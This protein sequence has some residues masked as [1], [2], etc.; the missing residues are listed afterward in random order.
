MTEARVW[1]EMPDGGSWDLVK[2]MSEN[3]DANTVSVELPNGKAADFPRDRTY[4]LDPSHL[5]D[6]DDLCHMNN[7]HEAPLLN[8]I[9]S[10]LSKEKIYTYTGDVLISLNPYK[11]IDGLYDNPSKYFDAP[12]KYDLD[13]DNEDSFRQ[14]SHSDTSLPP[15]VYAIA[16]YAFQAM[17]NKQ[18]VSIS[19]TGQNVCVNQSVIVSGESGAGK[20]EASKHVMNFLISTNQSILS[21]NSVMSSTVVPDVGDHIKGVLLE[22]SVV[23]EAFGNAKTVRN[24]NSSRF[25]KYIKLNYTA[26]NELVSA[27]TETFLLEKSRLVSVGQN[28]RNYHVFYQLVRGVAATNSSLMTELRLTSVDSF[29][30]LIGGKCTVVESEESDQRDFGMLCNALNVLGFSKEDVTGLWRL[31]ACILH[32]GNVTFAVGATEN[33]L[34]V[35][36]SPSISVEELSA[37][38]GVTAEAFSSKISTQKI[39][40]GKR[41]SFNIKTLSAEESSN[42]VMALLKWLYKQLFSWLV[43]QIN[44]AHACS[45]SKRVV[46]KY[47]GILDIFGFE[48]LG[49]NS[50]EQLCINY[51]NERLQQQFNDYVFVKEQEEYAT[52]G[53][54]WTTISYRNNQNVIDLIS[55]KPS[56]LLMILEEHGMMNRKPDDIAL[57]N[58]F[59]QKQ[60]RVSDAYAKSRFGNDGFVVKH[61]AGEV[62]YSIDGFL[63]KNNDS[64]QDDVMTMLTTSTNKF[65]VE[66]CIPDLATRG[67]SDDNQKKMAASVTVS[68]QFR[69][70]LDSLISTLRSTEPHYVKCIK[71]NAVKAVC[72]S[73][74]SIVM[75][76]LRY[77][78]ALEVVRIRREGYPTRMKFKDFY[79]AYELL[80][81]KRGW[82]PPDKCSEAEAKTYTSALASEFL[83]QIEFQ[84]GIRMVFMRN[85]C[86]ENM[87]AALNLCIASN[88][89]LIQARYRSFR[90]MH[91]FRSV[92]KNLI[93]LQGILRMLPKRF[94][95][96]RAQAEKKAVE[97][98]AEAARIAEKRKREE[99]ERLRLEREAEE[100]AK[101]L[102][103]KARIEAQ[104]LIDLKKHS[105][106]RICRALYTFRRNTLLLRRLAALMEAVVW[107]KLDAVKKLGKA[108]PDDLSLF[109][110]KQLGYTS[111]YYTA[112]ASGHEPIMAFLKS[113]CQPSPFSERGFNG[114]RLAHR[115]ARRPTFKNMSLFVALLD[116]SSPH[117]AV[118]NTKTTAVASTTNYRLEK[119]ISLLSGVPST[120]AAKAG[121]DK[122]LKE[123]WGS[124]RREGNKWEVRWIVLSDKELSY[125]KTKTDK[126]PRGK[127]PYEGSTIQRKRGDSPIL[128]ILSPSLLKRGLFGGGASEPAM[129][130]QF[131]S[132]QEL[133]SWLQPLKALFV[134]E[135]ARLRTD[136]P[137]VCAD[138][139]ARRRLL[140]APNKDGDTPLHALAKSYIPS[141]AQETAGCP[142]RV[143]Y[144]LWLLENGAN[145]ASKNKAGFSAGEIAAST[146]DIQ[147]V[148]CLQTS[149]EAALALTNLPPPIK[150]PL[151]SY[152]SMFFLEMSFGDSGK[153]DLIP[154]LVLSVYNH[155]SQLVE[156]VQTIEAPVVADPDYACW[157]ITWHMQTPLENVENGTFIAIQA[158]V[159]KTAELSRAV[160]MIEKEHMDSKMVA[161]RFLKNVSSCEVSKSHRLPQDYIG[162]AM[163]EAEISISH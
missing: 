111:L 55:K 156:P 53:L 59:N 57:L 1:I 5:K 89:T 4:P 141:A 52:E 22:S 146:G 99:G 45:D 75:E 119:T 16:N 80:A 142:D 77:S 140:S 27:Y 19:R 13:G 155:R 42:N 143:K 8:M 54:N 24:D 110:A 50:F 138:F 148:R 137:V 67:E 48:I 139:S 3:P 9:C 109:H 125:Y 159:K 63:S 37:L 124:K 31:L 93:Q 162:S 126:L 105:A 58:S 102:D 130:F 65:L 60:D 81:R 7:L 35:I 150:L 151:Y 18:T 78:G 34:P 157:G 40:I 82:V 118:G 160:Y 70:Q 115:I 30:M 149:S 56:G 136:R 23:L 104:A 36:S 132:E 94:K 84:I 101:L 85:G 86:Y 73:V 51:T 29:K 98:A 123:G 90:E 10:R 129:Y 106:A 28:E 133:Q 74:P 145:P 163:I 62:S 91:K 103:D 152:L 158:V 112:L 92:R 97:E 12:S 41:A 131:E 2:V 61:F 134:K 113:Y 21:S 107:G 108:N 161:I 17:S 83:K 144:A 116:S 44:S 20:T 96:K 87:L 38:L 100:L 147:L 79:E 117:E 95:F 71:P 43:E 127:I 154:S 11:R 88:A 120:V 39:Q 114:D 33:D 14:E 135:E 153:M 128:E 66:K 76:Q 49:R 47:I 15:H 68:F 46:T 32:L 6:L 25:G 69:N 122:I 64:L 26:E 121:G 72:S